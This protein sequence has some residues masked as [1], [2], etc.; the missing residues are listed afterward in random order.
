MDRAASR[1]AADQVA[2]IYGDTHRTYAELARRVRRLAH[3]LRSLGVTAGDRVG[4]LGPNHPAFLESLF[5]AATARR[6]ADADQPPA[7]AR[8]DR[9]HL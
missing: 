8:L 7:G 9:G 5:A 2:L 1:V 6:G 3:G 4:W